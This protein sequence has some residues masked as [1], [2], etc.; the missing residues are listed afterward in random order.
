MASRFVSSIPMDRLTDFCRRNHIGRLA[1]FGS[2]LREDFRRDSHIDGLAEFERG[3]GPGLA[4]FGMQGE[5][6][7]LLGRD[8]D[9]HTP[10]S[11]SRRFRAEVLR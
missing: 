11:L 7:A 2:V 3:H 6:S 4:F 8:V 1:F 5:L 10:Q 9:P